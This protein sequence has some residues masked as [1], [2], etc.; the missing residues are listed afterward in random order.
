MRGAKSAKWV[1]IAAVVALGAT[2]CG[3]GSGDSGSDNGKGEVDPKGIFSVDVGEPQNPLQ[4]AN[5]KE[6]NGSKVIR[7]I[8]SQLVDFD[9][10]GKIIYENA[11][12]IKTE[13]N[14]VWTVTLRDG[15]K[16]HNGEPVT[17]KSYVD[18]WNWGANIKNNQTNSYW[19]SDIKG[20]EDVHPE[21][22]EPKSD[23]M[24]GLKVIDDKTFTIE[25]SSPIPYFEY[26]LGYDVW[27]PLPSGFFKDPEAYGEKPVGNGPY[28]FVKWEHKKQIEVKTYADYKGADKPKNGGV[29]FKNYTTVEAGYQDL[30]SN[31]LDIIRQIGPK[32]LPKRKTDLGDRAVDE[33]YNAVQSIVP[34]F[35]TKQWKDI[36]PK[37]LQGLS[38]AIDRETITK[39]VLNGTREPATSFVAKGVAGYQPGIAGDILTYNPDK[40]KQLIKE[41]GGVPGNKIFIQFNADGGHK[42]WVEAVCNSIRKATGVE[43][44]GDSKPDFQTDLDTRDAHK[45]KSMYRGGWV[46]DYP[47]NVNFMRDLYGSKAA[48]NTSGFADKEI[49]GL[50]KKGDNAK[51][52]DSAIKAYQEAE[53]AMF[54]KMPAIPLWYYKANYG[55]STNVKNVKFDNNGD[56][57]LQDVEVLKK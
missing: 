53:K 20:F 56:P 51:D 48:G 4:P 42:E 21:K 18:A 33:P 36:D 27:S 24:S 19:F 10:K 25:L 30:L 37:V 9:D 3:G 49:D 28:E 43:C 15:W 57:V 32:D 46:Q 44:A 39:T 2:A 35:Y 29:I 26:K 7:A 34:A 14:K 41:G 52:L 17:A 55:Y 45:V 31:N 40:A 23:K 1:A 5:A 6:S 13:D 8:F 54:E 38:M 47:L 11:E 16:F 50:F 22:G 12:S